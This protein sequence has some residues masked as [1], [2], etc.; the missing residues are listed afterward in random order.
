MTAIASMSWSFSST[1]AC[2]SAAAANTPVKSFGYIPLR[3]EYI[4]WLES[5]TFIADQIR[6]VSNKHTDQD[7]ETTSIYKSRM[8][9]GACVG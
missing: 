9:D 4:Q 3:F 7:R 2:V 6:I 1:H 8:V 5:L